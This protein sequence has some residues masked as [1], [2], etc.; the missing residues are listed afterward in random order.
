MATT[1]AELLNT[2]ENVLAL[3]DSSRGRGTMAGDAA[4]LMSPAVIERL[5][6]LRLQIRRKY[7]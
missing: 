7:A 1:P 6:D 5:R 4:G 3:Y 2:V